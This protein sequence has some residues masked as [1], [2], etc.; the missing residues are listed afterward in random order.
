MLRDC[1]VIVTGCL[2]L[3]IVTITFFFKIVAFKMTALEI[4]SYH[5][6]RYWEML[7]R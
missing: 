1:Q 6:R 3:P 5:E 2:G 4:I 7:V